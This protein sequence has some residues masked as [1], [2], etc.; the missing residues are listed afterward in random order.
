MF[1][2]D[3][4]IQAVHRETERY[5]DAKAGEKKAIRDAFLSLKVA[6]N[7]AILK[8]KLCGTG[9][10]Y[11]LTKLE[12]YLPEVALELNDTATRIKDVL[13][14]NIYD[15]LVNLAN[16]IVKINEQIPYKTLNVRISPQVKELLSGLEKLKEEVE[17][18]EK[19][20]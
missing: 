16:D 17:K 18:V 13:E 12:L 1:G 8:V 11:L 2:I 15:G 14:V 4:I 19:I 6:L 5:R 7:T 3:A 10:H 9:T 20:G